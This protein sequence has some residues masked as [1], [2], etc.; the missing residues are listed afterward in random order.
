MTNGLIHFHTL[1]LNL[2]SVSDVT[3]VCSPHPGLLAPCYPQELSHKQ[4]D[5]WCRRIVIGLLQIR[6]QSLICETW[7]LT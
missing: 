5:P 4:K 7:R 2:E 3:P 6:E 1:D